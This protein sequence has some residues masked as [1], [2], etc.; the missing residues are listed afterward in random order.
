MGYHSVLSQAGNQS[1]SVFLSRVNPAYSLSYKNDYCYCI[2]EGQTDEK[3]YS[4]YLRNF[5]EKIKVIPVSKDAGVM[6][7]N[8]VKYYL[9]YFNSN[10][11]GSK[12][13]FLFF[14]DRDFGAYEAALNPNIPSNYGGSTFD[15]KTNPEN[16]YVTDDYS[17]E[18]SIFTKETIR[19]LFQYDFKVFQVNGGGKFMF[20]NDDDRNL[21]IKQ[22]EDLFDGQLR[23]FELK[24]VPI[25]SILIWCKK[26]NINYQLG[27]FKFSDLFDIKDT[28]EIIFQYQTNGTKVCEDDCNYDENQ[29]R[30][31]LKGKLYA[32]SQINEN[33]V[34]YDEVSLI[35]N[36]IKEAKKF[37][38]FRGH[39]IEPFWNKFNDSFKKITIN[40]SQTLTIVNGLKMNIVYA[41][42]G[43]I[44]S[45]TN[46]A[47]RTISK[48]G[49]EQK[50][51][52]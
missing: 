14:I 5:Y 23:K 47:Q 21:I 45:L 12:H 36:D 11:I 50:T 43:Y 10:Q 49:Q 27:N 30:L 44:K 40:N 35:E 29:F 31:E 25:I 3:F 38:T 34:N 51:E 32:K 28:G 39:F 7:C 1:L 24:F 37:H 13:Q 6:N 9:D 41:N 17:I 15:D 8:K 2:V 16:L 22:I 33:D 42:C 4:V 18:N 46:F 52:T 20:T 48:F 19:N 26:N